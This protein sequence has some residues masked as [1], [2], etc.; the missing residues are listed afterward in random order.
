M[1]IL[2]TRLDNGLT[3]L[4]E[5]SHEAPVVAL[6][7]WVHVGSADED[8]AVAGIAHVHEHMLFKGTA[9]RGV[10]EIARTVEGCGGEINAWTSFDETVYHLVLPADERE[11]G[12]DILADVLAGSAFDAGE[13]AR[14]IEVVLEEVRRAED[15]PSRRIAKAVTDIGRFGTAGGDSMLGNLVC[16]A[17]QR[18]AGVET[19][20][21]T[22]WKVDDAGTLALMTGFYEE[23]GR[24]GM[25]IVYKAVD[26]SLKRTVALKVLIAGEDASE[27]AIVRFHREAESVATTSPRLRSRSQH[28]PVKIWSRI[29]RWL[30]TPILAR[31]MV[32][33]LI[34]SIVTV[35]S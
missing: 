17:M 1:T 7:A 20:V 32:F 13:L 11:T 34:P 10:G 19:L 5:E 29:S 22:L 23:L 27:E 9:R 6:Q 35:L 30:T 14:E 25:G 8:E 26:A 24:G 18:R 12:L 31:V 3:L 15:S 16:E 4:L 33:S 21:G 2:R 28:L